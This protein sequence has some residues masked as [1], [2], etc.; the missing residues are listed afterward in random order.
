MTGDRSSAQGPVPTSLFDFGLCKRNL[1]ERCDIIEPIVGT[2]S[3]T[4]R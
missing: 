4:G 2:L 1:I 3:R